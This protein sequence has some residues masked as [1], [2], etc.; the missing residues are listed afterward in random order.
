M[1][2]VKNHRTKSVGAAT[3]YAVYGTYEN[4]RN[5]DVRAAAYS[6]VS[7][8]PNATPMQFVH[9]TVAEIAR[10]PRRSMFSK[11]SIPMNSTKI[12]PSMF[13]SHISPVWNSPAVSR[14]TAML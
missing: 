6:V 3:V 1:S 13:N 8:T 10:H 11:I 14:R 5:D 12:T 2:V 7:A 9:D 4:M